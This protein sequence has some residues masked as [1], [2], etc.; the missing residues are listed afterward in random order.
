MGI[1]PASFDLLVSAPQLG[2]LKPSEPNAQRVLELL[3]A[4]PETTLF[5]GDRYD[6]DAATANAVGA[7]YLIVG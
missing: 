5:V 3:Q 6:K 2:A 7:K 1:D 4:D